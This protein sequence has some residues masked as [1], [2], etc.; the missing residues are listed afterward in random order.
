MAK[1]IK[2][3][4][5]K[6]DDVVVISGAHK[7]GQGKV[8][9]VFPHKSQV[10]VEGVRMIKKHTRRSQDH[11]EA[12]GQVSA[13]GQGLTI[14]PLASDCCQA[15]CRRCWASIALAG[16]QKPA[17]RERV[18]AI[19]ITMTVI[20]QGFDIFPSLCKLNQP[21]PADR[22]QPAVASQQGLPSG[23]LHQRPLLPA[24]PGAGGF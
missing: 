13:Q 6:N 5:K 15:R 19:I 9:Q 7:G 22:H 17:Q 14:L 10:I 3:H 21:S 18:P 8:L 23:K 12:T 24:S 1:R 11:P 16:I 4:V 20:F 2:T